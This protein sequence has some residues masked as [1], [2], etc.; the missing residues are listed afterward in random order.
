MLS[1]ELKYP[2]C[3]L[4]C[5]WC[6]NIRQPLQWRSKLLKPWFASVVIGTI[7]GSEIDT[8]R[9]TEIHTVSGAEIRTAC[10]TEITTVSGAEIHT[11]HGA[12]IYSISW[13]IARLL[14]S[15]QPFTHSRFFHGVKVFVFVQAWGCIDYTFS[16]L[17]NFIAFVLSMI[18]Q[19]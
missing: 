13:Y 19:Y 10:G 14:H 5:P 11:V 18:W 1:V 17:L 2:Q 7:R 16:F 8:V 12:E 6:W 4:H 9:G 3:W 15:T